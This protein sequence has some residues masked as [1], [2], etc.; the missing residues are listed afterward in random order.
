MAET[1]T[2]RRGKE[3]DPVRALAK[4]LA[5]LEKA[6]QSL[7]KSA[8][9][10]N[11]S[12]SGGDGLTVKDEAG[13]VRLRISTADAAIIAYDTDGDEVARYGLLSHSDPGEYG[14]E[15]LSG[16]TWVHVGDESVTWAGVAGKPSTFAPDPHT[17]PGTDVTSAVASATTAATATLAAQAD[18]SQYGFDNTVAGTTF[19]A[20]WVGNDGGYHFGRNTSS[21]RYKE[22]VRAFTWA[23]SAQAELAKLRPVVYDRKTQYRAPMVDGLPAEGPAVAIPGA[24]GEFGL[25]AEEVHKVWPEVVTWWDPEDGTPARIDGIRYDL[26]AVRLIPLLQEQGTRLAA[27]ESAVAASKVEAK[28]QDTLIKDLTRRLEQLEITP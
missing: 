12:I 19:Y 16:G 18:G 11:A 7:A 23:G 27:L 4:K 25:I 21:I 9:L 26:I 6:V 1:G 2:P 24:R 15:A 14:I 28:R 5:D 13:V 3:T 17:H 10:R 8:N 22:N 20:L